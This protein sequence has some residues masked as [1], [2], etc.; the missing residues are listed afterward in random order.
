MPEG[1]K[2]IDAASQGFATKGNLTRSV[3]TSVLGRVF[4]SYDNR[5]LITATIRRDGS[6]KFA[7][8]NRYGNF[9][10]VSFRMEY[11]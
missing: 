3:L 9:P 5:Y 11:C 10:S 7:S 6:S 4:Y 2:E 1:I 8:S